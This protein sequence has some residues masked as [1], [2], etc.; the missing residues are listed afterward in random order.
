MQGAAVEGLVECVGRDEVV[1]VK[2]NENKVL[3]P[4]DVS[5]GLI[6]ASRELRIQVMADICL[7]SK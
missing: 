4:S 3:G 2:R 7:S 6:A 5:M 1:D